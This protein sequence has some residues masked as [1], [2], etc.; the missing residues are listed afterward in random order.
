MEGNVALDQLL[1]CDEV[2]NGTRYRF[3]GWKR[4][5]R[6]YRT[7]LVV[8]DASEEAG[9]CILILPEWD[10]SAEVEELLSILP[11]ELRSAGATGSCRADLTSQSAAALD[12]HGCSGADVKGLSRTATGPH[13]DLLAEGQEFRRR[14]DQRKFRLLDINAESPTVRAWNGSQVVRLGV[15]PLLA[16]RSDGTGLRYVYLGGGVAATRRRRNRA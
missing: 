4:L 3:H 12:I 6:G 9:Q 8:V 16:L 11:E 2:G 10:P 5:P 13:P 14:S 15:Q 1:A 7:K